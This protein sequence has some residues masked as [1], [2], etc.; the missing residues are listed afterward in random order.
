MAEAQDK[1]KTIFV[2][3][4]GDPRLQSAEA[5]LAHIE[6]ALH[7]ASNEARAH[8]GTKTN[9]TMIGHGGTELG[10]WRYTRT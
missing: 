6:Q 8:G 7:L 5:E 3:S 9:G 1:N 10:T 4:V 2:V